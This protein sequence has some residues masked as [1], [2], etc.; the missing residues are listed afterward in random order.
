L[1][2]KA[3][4]LY[5]GVGYKHGSWRDTGWWQYEIQ[6]EMIPPPEPVH[7]ASVAALNS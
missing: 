2:F 1:G 3:V 6:P 7:L 4:A 5:R